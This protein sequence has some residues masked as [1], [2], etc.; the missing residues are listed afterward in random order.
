M[1]KITL[2]IL[3]FF[4]NHCIA[5]TGLPRTVSFGSTDGTFMF[6][7]DIV[8]HVDNA[9]NFHTASYDI[10]DEVNSD[11]AN[12]GGAN[13]ITLTFDMSS[14][15][16]DPMGGGIIDAWV[17]T[18]EDIK[19]S[20]S[21]LV[22][23]LRLGQTG[24]NQTS[25]N[26]VRDYKITVNFA[27][28][29]IMPA[30]FFEID[31]NSVNTAGKAFESLAI[32]LLKP[33]GTPYSN[34]PTFNGFYGANYIDAAC[35]TGPAS[36]TPTVNPNIY[37]NLAPG[38]WVAASTNTV[39]ISTPCNISGGSSGPYDG[40]S[41][42]KS[43]AANVEGGLA[44]TDLVGGFIF[45][46]RLQDVGL[47]PIDDGSAASE[48]STSTSFTSTLRGFTIGVGTRLPIE[49]GHFNAVKKT[50]AVQ[51]NWLT[52]SEE[53]TRSFIVERSWDGQ[54]FQPLGTLEAIGNSSSTTSYKYLD[55]NPN[56]GEN[57]YRL[58]QVDLD[59]SFTYSKIA[60]VNFYKNQALTIRPSLVE[61]SFNIVAKNT[62]GQM[63][64]SIFNFMGHKM[65]E[66]KVESGEEAIDASTL[67]SGQYII[68]I[69]YGNGKK[70]TRRF[71][72]F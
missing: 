27:N 61:N 29:L 52:L 65:M 44:N 14:P 11:F 38:N 66:G 35:P 5:Q 34:E 64:F 43:I 3:L 12:P 13:D 18:T 15:T 49:M 47:S 26:D 53:N 62:T 28:H 63:E 6:T 8:Q 7:G 37:T 39:D 57:Y 56:E 22:G 9:A 33:D 68:T 54:R 19:Q 45:H 30:E 60:L 32:T 48:S 69:L 23:N 16:Y 36:V 17:G 4:A 1:N 40:G 70:A 51:L 21:G 10:F 67:A 72:K 46:I 55:N 58:Q 20:T 2:A 71:T 42:G 25:V 50:D 41:S 31:F 59:G 24:T